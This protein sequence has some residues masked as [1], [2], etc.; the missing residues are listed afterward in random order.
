MDQWN[1]RFLL[2]SLTNITLD[3]APKEKTLMRE[4]TKIFE[5]KKVHDEIFDNLQQCQVL[6]LTNYD[7]LILSLRSR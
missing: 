1:S 4:E 3:I 2:H 7:P 5:V 6:V